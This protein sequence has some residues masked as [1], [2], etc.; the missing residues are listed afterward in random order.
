METVYNDF[1]KSATM[2]QIF[3]NFQQNKC[4]IFAIL[5]KMGATYYHFSAREM[6]SALLWLALPSL[7]AMLYFL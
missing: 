7:R 6:S 1:T 3:Y 4:G 2:L 5:R